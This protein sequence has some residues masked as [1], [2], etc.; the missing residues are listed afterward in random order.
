[1]SSGLL[2]R[3]QFLVSIFAAPAIQPAIAKPASKSPL[4]GIAAPEF[5]F[6]E[7]VEFRWVDENSGKHHTERGQIV[8]ASWNHPENQWEYAVTWHSSTAYPA[9]EYP[10]FDG[11]FVTARELCKTND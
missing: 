1:M 7:K 6:G 5:W 9:S 3:R 8:G 11:N 10:I 2:S 4:P